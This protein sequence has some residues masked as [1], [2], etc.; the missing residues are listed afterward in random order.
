M[1]RR[2]GRAR[3]RRV[4]ASGGVSRLPISAGFKTGHIKLYIDSPAVPGWN[5]ID[6]VGIEDA[7]KKV[8][9][10]SKAKASSTYGSGWPQNSGRPGYL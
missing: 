1:K 2:C 4:G 7:N 10:A 6:A 8:I 9:W 5:E 3:I